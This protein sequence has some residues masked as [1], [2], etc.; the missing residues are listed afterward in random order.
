MAQLT[1]RFAANRTVREYTKQHYLPAA[2]AYRTRSANGGAIGRQ[3]VESRHRLDED[4]GKVRFGEVKV[5]SR[6]EQHVFEVHVSL[7]DLDPKA[8]RVEVYA[9][10]VS[11]GAPVRQEMKRVGTLAGEPG[12]YVYRA[13]VPA[14][15]PAADYTA[16][17][18]TP[19]NDA[20][21]PLEDARILWQR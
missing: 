17:V 4:W 11:G 7:N 15:R 2:A 9:D 13:A 3:M 14:V 6:G 18:M 5:E 21:I 12:G 10:G 16:R 20:A 8:V 1:P 19:G